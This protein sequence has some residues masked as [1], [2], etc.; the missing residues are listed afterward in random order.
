MKK[1]IVLGLFTMGL[2]LS[3]FLSA[4]FAAVYNIAVTP[5]NDSVFFWDKSGSYVYTWW[6][7]TASP[8]MV[9]HNY[10]Y[11]NRAGWYNDTS[12]TFSLGSFAAAASDIVSASFNIHVLDVWSAG[13]E[14]IGSSSFGS[15]NFSEGIGWKSFDAT[16]YIMSLLESGSPTANFSIA[17][18][19]FSGFS[20]GSADGGDPAFLRITTTGAASPVPVPSTL[21]LLGGG[22][23][24]L[25]GS[26]RKTQ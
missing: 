25:A 21:L 7:N 17:H 15:V 24:V 13:R 14:D 18:T 20:F 16:K 3:M 23:M 19:A 4:S 8:N 5:E 22:M 10:D 1:K 9:G 12:L 26:R 11:D 2:C 6:D